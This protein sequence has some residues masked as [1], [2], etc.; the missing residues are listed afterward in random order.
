MSEKIT[1][2]HLA[3]RAMLYIRQ[4]TPQQLLHNEESRRLQYAMADRLRRLGWRDVELVDEDLGK[5]AAGTV[6]RTG[7]QRLVSEVSLGKVGAVGARELSRLARNSLDWQRLMEVCRYVDTLLVDHDAVYDVR[8]AN[9]RLL[10]G[11][12]GNLNEYELDLLRLRAFEA[13]LEKA[14]RGDYYA[15]VAVGYCKTAV[16]GLEKHPDARVQHAIRLVFEKMLELGSARQLLLWMRE[17]GLAVPVNG[18]DRGEIVWKAVSYG[19]IHMVLTNPVYAGA[20]V[21]GRT[22]T[23]AT[24]TEQ[25]ARQRRVVARPAG[26]AAVILLPDRHEGYIDPATFDR[27]QTLMTRNSQSRWRPGPGAARVGQALLAGLLRC[28]RCGARLVVNYGGT[29][30]RVHRYECSRANASR[31]EARCINFSG[32]DV[33]ARLEEL[34]LEV[35]QPG[36]L[37]AADQLARQHAAEQDQLLGTLQ[38]ELQAARYAAERAQRQYDAVEPENRLVVDELERRWNAALARVQA[39]EGRLEQ[40]RPEAERPP[41]D[42]A[43]LAS[44]AADVARV[45]HGPAT[46]VRLKK[47]ILRTLIEEIV[48]D[49]N[50]RDVLLV[51]H[52]QGGIHTEVTVRR[53]RRG[54]NRRQTSADV[55][56][57]V[58]VLA[59]VSADEHIARALNASGITTA[60]GNPWTRELVRS[61]RSSHQIPVYA[62]AGDEAWVT[63]VRAAQLVGVA[64]LTLKR[65][66]ER[67]VVAALRPVARGPWVLSKAALLRPQ[68]LQRITKKPRPQSGAP[69]APNS[70]QLTL[71]IPRL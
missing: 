16:G 60:R 63:L 40:A 3:R 44:L 61:F 21:Y 2:R 46:D 20:Y 65:A 17:H 19:W 13:R 56:E 34:A 64:E 5:S 38:L 69:A 51:V 9:D 62:R 66:I 35:V 49:V 27:I 14:R 54:E 36:A 59:R 45:W 57:A 11:L 58:R 6:E 24:L 39:I 18:T 42:T 25:G 41:V 12:K 68:V 30:V 67:G 37:E 71:V 33:D 31:G 53:R 10:L 28:R 29:A 8:H 52:W 50:E 7:F 43:R 4:S 47:R 1:A 15:R 23:V 70:K 26:D 55:T 48:A 32:L 22:V